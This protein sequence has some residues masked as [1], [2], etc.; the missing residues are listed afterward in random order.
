VFGPEFIFRR[1]AFRRLIVGAAKTVSLSFATSSL[2][3]ENCATST[4]RAASV[5]GAERRVSILSPPFCA[6]RDGVTPAGP[7]I[8]AAIDSLHQAG[9]GGEVLIPRGDFN[10]AAVTLK[11]HSNISLVGEGRD[12]SV[13]RYKGSVAA[14]DLSG[15][16]DAPNVKMKIQ[17]IGIYG[18]S[19]K[20]VGLK[21][22]RSHYGIIDNVRVYGFWDGLVAKDSWNW[23]FSNLSAENCGFDGVRLERDANAI[24]LDSFCGFRNSRAGLSNEGGRSILLNQPCL[25]G[26]GIGVLI[27]SG[28]SPGNVQSKGLRINGGYFE[29][30]TVHE[31]KFVAGA[32]GNAPR[33]T[34]IEGTMF[35]RIVGG[36]KV[37]IYVSDAEGF[38][39]RALLFDDAGERYLHSFHFAKNRLIESVTVGDRVDKS[40][41]GIKSN[42]EIVR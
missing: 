8:Q 24:Q 36:T 38:W 26:N 37:A 23:H 39:A 35:T 33:A 16:P 32:S 6:P 19:S 15:L 21:L 17:N 14:L 42:V 30:N 22:E 2:A 31:I 7:A 4:N 20:A 13:L 11:L 25:E 28:S 27:T 34:S 10:L 1:D 29:G 40:L 41:R 12:S 18:S 5:N 3:E 9:A